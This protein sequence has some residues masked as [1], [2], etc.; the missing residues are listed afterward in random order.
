M[1]RGASLPRWR[2]DAIRRIVAARAALVKLVARVPEDAARRPRALD[3]WSV[4]DMLAHLVTCDEET[5]RRLRLIERG[6][7]GRIKWFESM[8]D[9][10][11]FN[12][13]SVSRLRRVGLRP[14]IRRMER[15][16]DDLVAALER[17][18]ASS[19]ADPRHAYPVVEWLPAPG[20]SHV[21]DHRREIAEWWRTRRAVGRPPR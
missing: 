19:L 12:A 5:L 13:R 2:R 1:A 7:A 17:L 15:A 20:W 21:D 4:K 16:S 3:R 14:L 8:A 9:A 11:R 10:D 6:Q 18:P